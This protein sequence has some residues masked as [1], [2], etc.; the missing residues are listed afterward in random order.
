MTNPQ[1]ESNSASA[2]E[3]HTDRF[4]T[5]TGAQ[6]AAKKQRII[7]WL[8]VYHAAVG[9]IEGLSSIDDPMLTFLF[10]VPIYI[11]VLSWCYADANERGRQL[12]K[13][14][15]TSLIL[16]FIVAFPIYLFRTRGIRG[17]QTLMLSLLVMAG[18]FA[19]WAVTLMIGSWIGNATNH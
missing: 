10:T 18:M 7:F 17:F 2:G 5:N 4:E 6:S 13:G 8:F 1:F 12:S 14:E 3:I 15:S 16:F 19:T 9:F 11:M